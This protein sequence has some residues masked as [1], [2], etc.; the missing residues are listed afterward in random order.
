M[1]SLEQEKYDLTA[2]KLNRAYCELW[3]G[4]DR[5]F[6]IALLIQWGVLITQALVISPRTWIGEESATHMH[7]WSALLLGGVI[8]VPTAMM[9]WF[10]R[11]TRS[12]RLAMTVAQALVVSLMIHFGGGRIEWHFA[13]FVSLAVL[14]IYRDPWVLIVM[15]GIVAVDHMARGIF[16]PQSIYGY[17]GA[18]QWLWLE[19]AVWVLIEV[20]LLMAGI[21]R[22]AHEMSQIAEREAEL[23]LVGQVGIARSV[24][25]MIKDIKHIETTGDLTGQVDARFDGVTAELA[26][27]MNSFITTLRGIIEEVHSAARE[28]S[29]SSMSISAGTQEMAQTAESMHQQ[30]KEISVNASEASSVAEQGSQVIGETIQN[31]HVIGEGVQ[32]GGEL[33]SQLDGRSQ[34][35][36]SLVTV[37][38]DIADQTNLLALNAAIESA[39]AGEHGRGFAV[40]ADEVRKLADRTASVTEEIQ[41]AI[42]EINTETNRARE[43]MERNSQKAEECVSQSATAAEILESI[44]RRSRDVDADIEKLSAGFSEVGDA[45]SSMSESVTQLAERN[46]QLT[47]LA[48]QFTTS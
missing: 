44:L 10:R 41:H 42:S 48:E 39:R 4:N 45:S 33:V 23:E 14:A 27:T 47:K 21:R 13:V 24:D 12:A 25:G 29:S 28:A 16:W 6:A 7:V 26:Q 8:C 18:G 32:Q 31:L 11:G 43:A 38:Q 17:V 30:A 22:S 20:G 15:T 40:V 19:H 3:K 37:I 9:G 35:I 34:H 2:S 46:E 36:G 1:I 5:V